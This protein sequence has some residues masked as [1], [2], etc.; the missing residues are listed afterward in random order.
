MDSNLIIDVGVHT[1]QDTEF[2]LKKGFRVIGIEAH[3]E[4]YETAKNRLKSYI[5][6]GQLTLLNIAISPKDE[7]ITF[8]ANLD[9]SFWGTISPDRVKE[10]DRSF[11]TRSVEMTVTGRRFES[12]LAEFGVPYYLKIDIEGS[13]LLCVKALQQFDTKPQFI[14]IESTKAS[15]SALLEEIE[16]LKELGYQKFKAVNQAKVTQ[17]VAPSPPREGKYIPYQFEYGASGLFG[18]ETPGNWL[19]E[20]EVIKAYKGIFRNYKIF[21]VNGI[22]YQFYA[23]KMLL[24][25]LNIKEPWYDTHASL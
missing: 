13:D 21:G 1:G 7:P 19:S 4:I 9:R 12:I 24:E 23:G 17:Q 11:G 6:S 14:S 16:L 18:E 3:P 5:E 15:W 20:S 25:S 8:Y 2:Y 22:I 10:S